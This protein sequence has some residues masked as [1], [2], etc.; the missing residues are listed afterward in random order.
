MA[1]FLKSIGGFIFG[2]AI[3]IGIILL[4]MFFIKGGVWVGSKVLPWL[5]IIMW[6]LFVVDII[7]FL[8]LGIFK[9]TKG[10]ASFGFY[11]SAYVYGLTIWVWS[12]LLTYFFWG[13]LAVFIGLFIAGIGVIPTAILAT[14]LN[15][16]LIVTG[17]I[18]LLLI[19]TFV[20]NMLGNYFAE[21]AEESFKKDAIK[22]VEGEEI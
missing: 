20:T 15:G 10:I 13:A 1:N 12:L 18:V 14:A 11:L 2:I 16:E 19:F 3:L 7:I 6:I 21:K 5:S 17:Q 22:E 9:K 4:A 8:P